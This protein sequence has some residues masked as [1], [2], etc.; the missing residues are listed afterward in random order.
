MDG[1]SCSSPQQAQAFLEAA[2]TLRSGQSPAIGS[3]VQPPNPAPSVVISSEQDFAYPQAHLRTIGD[4]AHR[5][6]ARCQRD[7][8]FYVH[9]PVCWTEAV[10]TTIRRWNTHRSAR[11]RT[12]GEI[13]TAGGNGH[14]RA[15]GGAA[16]NTALC[17]WIDRRAIMVILATQAVHQLIRMRSAL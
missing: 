9:R 2:C 8:T 14:R 15:A 17:P 10:H 1:L 7:H 11:V 3:G 4:P 12:Q 5:V 16:G 13:H 6:K